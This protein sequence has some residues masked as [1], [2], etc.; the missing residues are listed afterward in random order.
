MLCEFPGGRSWLILGGVDRSDVVVKEYYLVLS[1]VK[2]PKLSVPHALEFPEHFQKG[3][4]VDL[5]LGGQLDFFYPVFLQDGFVLLLECLLFG[6]LFQ[7][8]RSALIVYSILRAITFH[9]F[10]TKRVRETPVFNESY[11]LGAIATLA[12]FCCLDR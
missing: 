11:V 5:E 10:C 3:R 1:Y 12:N 8:V 2:T 4:L 7:A 6:H 9:R